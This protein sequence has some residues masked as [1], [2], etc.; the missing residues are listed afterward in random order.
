MLKKNKD[1]HLL[2]DKMA[3]KIGFKRKELFKLPKLYAGETWWSLNRDC[4]EYVVD[5]TKGTKDY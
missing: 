1:K 2:R 5:Y 3:K 4:L